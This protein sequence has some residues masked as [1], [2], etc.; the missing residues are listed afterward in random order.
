M[1]KKLR[2]AGLFVVF[3]LTDWRVILGLIFTLMAPWLVIPAALFVVAAAVSMA[4]QATIFLLVC[5]ALFFGGRACFYLYARLTLSPTHFAAWRENFRETKPIVKR[6][7]PIGA[8]HYNLRVR[9][10]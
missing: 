6:P 5:G 3:I 2:I 1:T 8:V 7:L 10:D 4:V 9:H